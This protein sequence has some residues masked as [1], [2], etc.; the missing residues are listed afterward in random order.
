MDLLI[1]DDDELNNQILATVL[2]DFSFVENILAFNDGWE[3]LQ[4]LEN[5]KSKFPDILLIDLKMPT[6]EGEDFIRK[7]ESLFFNEFPDSK[8]IV[9]TNSTLSREKDNVMAYRS[10][11]DFITKPV[12]VDKLR[13]VLE[14]FNRKFVN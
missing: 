9:L 8:L 6:M 7:Y 5:S 11:I 14:R 4:F 2:E 3:V 10:V 13:E 1:L 12:E